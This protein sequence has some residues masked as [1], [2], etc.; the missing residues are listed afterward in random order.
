MACTY[1]YRGVEYTKNELLERLSI[2]LFKDL[3]NENIFR[4]IATK[5]SKSSPIVSETS[6]MLSQRYN[7]AKNMLQAIKNSDDTKEEKLRKTAYYKNI[8]E[9]TLLSRKEL[10]QMPADKQL[11]YVLDK[12]LSDA[13]LVDTLFKSDKITFNELRFANNVVDTWS[14]LNTGLGVDT[15]YDIADEDIKDKANLILNRYRELNDRTR[16]IAIKLLKEAGVS[17]TKLRETSIAT[18][19]VRELSTA[20]VPITNKLAYI[21]KETNFKINKEHNTNHETI[22]SKFN[23]IKDHPIFKQMGWDLFIKTQKNRDGEEVLALNT[24]YAQNFWD[25]LRK[26]N[27]S[28]KLEI[29]KA[30]T[31]KDKAKQAW[32]NYNKWMS[33]N[34]VPFNSVLFIN[35]ADHTDAERD[36]EVRRMKSLGF[37]ESEV[38]DIIA[39]SQKFYERFL[40][41]K[42][43]YQER[44]KLAVAGDPSIVPSSMSVDDFIKEKVDDYDNLNNPLKYIQQ[45]FTPGE[46]VTAY[47]GARYSYLI[48]SKEVNGIPSGYYDENFAKIAA[49]PKLYEFYK[50][51]TKFMDD[52]LDWLPQE[53]T[54]DLQ[55]NFL[56]VIADRVVKEYGFSALKESV[57]GMGDWFMKALTANNYE[58]QVEKAA[59]SKKE[60]KGF[61]ARYINENVTVEDRSKDLVLMAKLFSDMALV[62]KHKNSVSAQ[63]DIINDM[64]QSTQGSY[65][66][67]NKLGELEAVAKDASRLKSLVES[68]VDR[69]FYGL[70]ANDSSADSDKL[71]YDWRELVSLGLWQSEK[72]KQAKVLS[73]KIKEINEKLDKDDTLTDKEREKLQLE[74]ETNKADF[75]KLGGRK[76]SLSTAID[77]SIKGTRLTS[78][79]FAPFSAFR[80]LIVGKLNNNIHATGGR[81]FN[82]KDLAW[83]N[84]Q[85]IDSSGKYWSGGKFETRMTKLVFG[86]M[87]DAQ[88]AEGEDGIYLQTMVDKHTSLDKL[89]EMLPKAYTWL[90]SG[91]YHFKAEMLLACMKHEMITTSKGEKISFIDALNE[92]REYDEDKHGPW[93]AAA[94]GNMTFEEFYTKKMLAYKQIANKLH[95]ATGK[96]VYLKGKDTALGRLAMLFKSWLPETVGVRFDPKHR[97]ALLD[98]D[99]EGYYRTFLKK[100]AEKKLGIVKMMLQTVFNKDNG[101][102][103]PM[104]LA[105][106]KKAV[107]ELQVITAIL[108]AYLI[109]K[110]MTPDDDKKKKLYNLL[111]VRQLYDLHRDMTYYSDIH[112]IGDLQKEVFPVIR[113][114]ENWEQAVKA[115][116]YHFAGVENNQGQ[117]MYDNERT[118]LRITKVLPVFSNINR[119]NYYMKGISSGGRGY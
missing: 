37:N 41:N 84:K 31:D 21:I 35:S 25:N 111:V 97:D 59:F 94:N 110:A 49:D 83:S 17:D 89:R 92:N 7:D 80:N 67:N 52:S 100:V 58:Q 78:L 68:T 70:R 93:D 81:D 3:N 9:Q 38:N 18:Q 32:K 12:A 34:T 98:R 108:L 39:E 56:P 40:R 76:F 99:E 96:D 53:E 55:S 66:M 62:Y 60:R 104:E 69:S 19:F 86:L 28:R 106:F 47:G 6:L 77:S 43:E 63:I 95:G 91:D 11:D 4:S 112:S 8:M 20:G 51:Y 79:G 57:K 50:W 115:V 118:A 1:T 103:D 5:K 48:A 64:V 30:G 45:K 61:K 27:A 10:L 82:K 33:E 42:E 2:D 90:S 85:I 88:L 13:N 101:I 102:T 113:T 73:D 24:K 26:V 44:T 29:E 116:T 54:D 87:H 74:L 114:A 23:L 46:V 105:N 117:E 109:A 71:F 14:N 107:K 72:G 75:Y 36:A 22:D 119:V 65:K 15:I 16:Q